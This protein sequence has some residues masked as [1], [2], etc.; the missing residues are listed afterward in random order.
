GTPEQ[1]A[2]LGSL[3]VALVNQTLRRVTAASPRFYSG[4]VG[5]LPEPGEA[6]GDLL[7]TVPTDEEL[8]QVG[9]ERVP[10]ERN[11]EAAQYRDLCDSF[12]DDIRGSDDKLRLSA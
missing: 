4:M 1:L 11:R 10:I 12:R 9:A 6:Y 2:S 7:L 3:S 8:R 5:V